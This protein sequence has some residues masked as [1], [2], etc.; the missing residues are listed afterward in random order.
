MAMFGPGRIL[1]NDAANCKIRLPVGFFFLKV[2]IDRG[3][4]AVSCALATHKSAHGHGHY[5][6]HGGPDL[7]FRHQG[8]TRAIVKCPLYAYKTP[9]KLPLCI[10]RCP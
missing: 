7:V 4:L 10:P 3:G 8:H 2:A 6:A 5:H 9:T 1:I